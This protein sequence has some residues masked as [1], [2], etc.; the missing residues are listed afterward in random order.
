MTETPSIQWFP[1]HMKKTEREII[2][3][4]PLVD[5]VAELLDA[6]IPLSSQN[7]VLPKLLGG[8]PRFI[9]LNKADMADEN[10]TRKHIDFFREQGLMTLQTDCTTGKGLK[11]FEATVRTVLKEKIERN[12]QK[13]MSGKTIH[14]MIVGIPNVGKSTLINRLAGQK[15]AKTED[16]PGVT[17]NKQWVRVSDTCELLDMPG[18]LWPKFEDP[19]VA[20]RLAFT[21]A[22][23]DDIVDI[24]ALAARLI[25]TLILNYKAR[26]ENRYEIE[27]TSDNGYAVLIEIAK[28]RGFL[29]RGGEYNTERAAITVLDEYR[30]KKLGKISLE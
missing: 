22:V 21:G 14:A 9:I 13:G 29:I 18:V 24:E 17:R 16:R 8:K 28:K 6:R 7:P 11:Q 15:K 3:S 26:L 20:E 5:I 30:G 2:K 12:A 27:I 4:L 10:I 19:I 23:K 25:E 1:G